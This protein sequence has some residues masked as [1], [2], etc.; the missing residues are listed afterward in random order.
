LLCDSGIP[1]DALED[2]IEIYKPQGIIVPS[3]RE[4]LCGIF[5]KQNKK[6][7]EQNIDKDVKFFTA[8]ADEEPPHPDLALLLT[9]SGSTG[10]RK[11]VR[12]SQANL[13]VNTEDVIKALAIGSQDRAAAH[14]PLAYSYG[15]SVLMTHLSAEA[16]LVLF[17]DG[18]TSSS[19]WRATREY[20]VT[21]LPGVPYHFSM[22][23]KLGFERLNIPA[24]RTMTQA[25]GR[26]EPDLVQYF[27]SA[28]KQRGGKFFVMYGQTEA[29][30]RMTTLPAEQALDK[31]ASVGLPMAHGRLSI[32]DGEIV[33]TGANVMMGYAESRADLARGDDM[34]GRLA[35]GDLGY[36]DDDGCLYITGRKKRFAKIDGLRIN[37]DDIDAVGKA[38]APVAVIEHNDQL[39]LFTT[40]EAEAVRHH[41]LANIRLH[42]SR[43]SCRMIAELPRLANDKI[44]MQALKSMLL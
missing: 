14:M 20:G 21:T 18:M 42:P 1:V 17:E 10:S 23:Q 24:V 35:T 19:F 43:V 33:Y 22:I 8:V 12:L 37:L 4:D 44:D 11:L 29:S 27:A 31:P 5:F 38:V 9:T 41:V 25:G 15:L 2:L 28:M 32:E 7:S 39:V 16:S 3:V 34:H 36:L 30:P 26:M 40:G 13:A 6:E